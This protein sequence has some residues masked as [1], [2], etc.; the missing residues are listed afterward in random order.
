MDR[1]MGGKKKKQTEISGNHK[2][3]CQ[4]PDIITSMHPTSL[5]SG[6]EFAIANF[7]V[8]FCVFLPV[9]SSESI[10]LF[11]DEMSMCINF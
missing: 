10:F 11:H 4:R 3:K 9:T 8:R 2:Y 6:M 5:P 7:E 1:M